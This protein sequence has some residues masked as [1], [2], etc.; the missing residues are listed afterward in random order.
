MSSKSTGRTRSRK[1]AV[2]RPQKPY[3]DFP[4]S[5]HASGTWQKKIRGKI[6]YF[7]RWGRIVCGTMV[8]IEGDGWREALDLY[9]AQA[10]DLHA[11]RTPRTPTDPFAVA[12]LCNHFLTSKKRKVDAAEMSSRM[13]DEYKL[14]TDRLVSKFGKN[15]LVADLVADDFASLRAD[16]AKQYG[17]VRLGN[18]IQKVRT[19]FKHALGQGLIEKPG[20]LGDEFKKPSKNVLRKHRNSVGKRMFEANELRR[21][22]VA[23]DNPLKA[24]ILLGINAA[25]G[26]ADCGHL[27]RAAWGTGTGVRLLLDQRGISHPAG[28]P[29]DIGAFES[30]GFTMTPL[31]GS[32]PFDVVAN[33]AV[34]SPPPLTV[35]V[36]AKDPLQ[37]VDGGVVTYSVLPGPGGQ[38][39]SLTAT[40]A[41]ISGGIAS[42]DAFANPILGSYPV[43]ARSGSLTATFTLVN[44]TGVAV[45]IRPVTSGL[46]DAPIGT[47]YGTL[48]QVKVTDAAGNPVAG[49]LVAFSAPAARASGVFASS[50]LV[51]TDAQGIATAPAFTA[52]HAI[53]AFNVTA[54][55]SG[56]TIAAVSLPLTNTAVPAKVSIVGPNLTRT[57]PMGATFGTPVKVS[58]TDAAGNPVV[59]ITVDFEWPA[60]TLTSSSDVSAAVVTDQ[61]GIATAPTWTAGKQSGTFTVNA[62]VTG[63]KAPAS[64]NFVV[65]PKPPAIT[66]VT[67]NHSPVT[68]STTLTITGSN[69]GTTAAAN[70]VTIGGKVAPVMSV[71]PSGTQL[72]VASPPGV[73]T[74]NSIVVTTG[75]QSSLPSIAATFNYD[76]PAISF[77]TPNHGP[78]LGGTQITITGVD[79]GTATGTTVT[80]GGKVAP[81]KTATATQLVV[82][83]PPGSGAGDPIVVTVAGQ[84]SAASANAVF[85]YDAPTISNVAPTHG[86]IVG[87][88]AVTITGTGFSPAFGA[89]TVTIDGLPAPIMSINASGTQIVVTAP[90]GPGT[91]SAVVVNVGGQTNPTSSIATFKYDAPTLSS[92]TPSHGPLAGGTVITL[93][94]TGFATTAQGNSVTIGGLPAQ[95]CSPSMPWARSSWSTRPL[96]RA[97]AP[98]LSSPSAIS[99]LR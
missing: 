34:G 94:G 63:V 50:P 44:Q 41:T 39:A 68:G 48:L 53:G 12:D 25:F 27:P 36:T 37:P 70:S 95:R 97:T 6:H 76:P 91:G 32:G 96:A 69:F 84:I 61:N 60:N 43:T 59:G 16:L 47:K 83:S 88:T 13:F 14:T 78:V 93:V 31:F 4:L 30:Q 17:P 8:R 15:R 33:Q 66:W 77:V 56:S 7:G 40:F 52:N 51:M 24:M 65:L 75:S 73:G 54:S 62:W 86:P 18:E 82:V 9:K 99:R 81:I 1:A 21:L 35:T 80:I 11:G 10:D 28:G 38:S 3:P 19:V 55:V 46:L 74:G 72:V 5:P 20:R 29:S 57:A 49:Q 22:I 98:A 23:A 79:F 85:T 87:G 89:T 64:F 58:V 67:P 42:V 92:L 71:D 90:P 26:N 45:A 2:A